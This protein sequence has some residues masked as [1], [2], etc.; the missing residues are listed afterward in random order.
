M[1]QECIIKNIMPTLLNTGVAPNMMLTINSFLLE[2][3]FADISLICDQFLDLSLTAFKFPDISR[4]SGKVV[5]ETQ[6]LGFCVTDPCVR[7]YSRFGWSPKVRFWELL[8]QYF[9]HARCPSYHP[10][11]SVKA[12]KYDSVPDWSSRIYKTQYTEW[13]LSSHDQIPWLFP[14]FS[15]YGVSTLATVAI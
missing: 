8:W 13:P 1:C 4:F 12:L 7:S 6:S 14:D 9:L 5:N 11:N 3:L 15:I 2:D 10:T